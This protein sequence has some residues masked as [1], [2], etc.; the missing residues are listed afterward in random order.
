MAAG[1]T[2]ARAAP[3]PPQRVCP[4]CARVAYATER[5]CPYCRRAYRRHTLAAVAAMLAVFAV[6]ILGGFYV[7]LVAAGDELDNRIDDQVQNVQGD[8]DRSVRGLEQRL[9]RQ[10]DER[11]PATP[12]P[13]PTP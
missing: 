10:L 4:H 13:V 12:S 2:A 5:R 11:L 3:P 1:E 9:Q 6:V 7:M 8:F